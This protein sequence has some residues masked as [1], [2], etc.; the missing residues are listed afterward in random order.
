M[1]PRPLHRISCLLLL[2]AG[3]CDCGGLVAPWGDGSDDAGVTSDASGDGGRGADAGGDAGYC[4]GLLAQTTFTFGLCVC[5]DL[6]MGAGFYTDGY[7]ASSGAYQ[8]GQESGSVGVHGT[9]RNYGDSDIGGTLY[10]GVDSRPIGNHDIRGELRVGGEAFTAGADIHIFND[11]FVVGDITGIRYVIDGTLHIPAASTVGAAVDA[12]QVVREPVVVQ[13]PCRCQGDNPVDITGRIAQAAQ[14]NDNA[15]IGLT[16]DALVDVTTETDL[17]LPP[18]QYYLDSVSAIWPVRLHLTGPTA[19]YIAGDLHST[20]VFE[21]VLETSGPNPQLDLFI[22]GNI[23]ATGQ[24]ELGT[25][26]LPSRVRAY[27]AGSDDIVLLGD[28]NLGLNLY[29]PYA[30]VLAA[31]PLEIWGALYCRALVEAGLV[32][33]HY[34]SDVLAAAQTCDPTAP[35]HLPERCDSCL[36]CGNQ[37]CR[38]NQ[39]TTC[40]DSTQCCPPLICNSGVCMAIG[41]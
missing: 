12:T 3:A 4:G 15:R 22:G 6:N 26:T 36:D 5:E 16:S 2:A 27:V 20:S 11:A 7:S 14:H 29:A 13:T 35:V 10:C 9:F 21:A 1:S 30:R 33:V 8:P 28:L 25:R 39:C 40:T 32:E 31:G 19:V 38:N 17:D 37:A 24:F 34:D 18:G 23:A 41:Y